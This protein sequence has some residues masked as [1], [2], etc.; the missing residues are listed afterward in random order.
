MT[1]TMRPTTNFD[2][3][4]T[5]GLIVCERRGHWA[6]ALGALPLG[7]RPL[8]TRSL[9]ECR[10]ALATL[11]ASIVAVELT[12]ANGAALLEEVD[13]W[14]TEYPKA[15]ILVLGEPDLE[16]WSEPLREAGAIHVV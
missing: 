14:R 4:M 1:R 9:A 11:P 15:R 16:P 3:T 12:A 13:R 5:A 8:Q 6:T 10:A 2:A 7:S